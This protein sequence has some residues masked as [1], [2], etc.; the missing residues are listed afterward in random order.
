MPN[1]MAALPALSVQHPKVSLTPTRVQCSN[2]G[3]M[4][5]P[6]KLS[7]VSKLPDGSQ[8]LVGRSSPYCKNMLLLNNF[9]RLSIPALVAKI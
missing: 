8:L 5:N 1:V 2:A 3:K 9:F 7:G 4:R 6:L